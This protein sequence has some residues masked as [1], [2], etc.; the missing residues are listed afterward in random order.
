M[1]RITK[2]LAGTGDDDMA[3]DHADPADA[4]TT[5]RPT[6]E[7]SSFSRNDGRRGAP[8]SFA[9]RSGGGRVPPHDIDAERSVLSALLLDN[10]Y[11]HDVTLEVSGEDFYHPSNMALFKA[12][13]SIHEAGKPVDLITLSEHLSTKGILD[14]IGGPVFLAEIADFEATA[15]NVVHHAQ[16]VRDK[17]VKRRLISVATEIV[18]E[19][20]V[21][22]G[23]SQELLDSAEG[24]ILDLSQGQ[25]RT[26]FIRLRDEMDDT[27][28]YV[29]AI[30]NRGGGLTGV[31]TGYEDLDK[32][33]GG[34]QAG[35]LVVIAARPSMGKTAL[36]LNVARNASIED[37]R[38]VAVFSLEM[39]TRSLILR[40]L[41][42]EARVDFSAFRSSYLPTRDFTKLT[43]AGDNLSRADLWIDDS[44]D[45]SLQEI[46]SK[47]RRL[48]AESGLDLVIV[49][50]LQLARGDE[51][52]R[53]RKDLE[54]AEISKGLKALAKELEIPV[55]ALSQ[56]NRGP[57]QRDPDKRRPRL[58]DL[59][60]SGAIEQDADLIAFI[61]RDHVYNKEADAA[62]AELIVEKQRNGPTGTVKLHFE[63]R[64][65]RFDNWTGREDDPSNVGQTFVGP[66]DSPVFSKGVSTEPFDE[67]P[68]F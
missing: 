28:D 67:D 22:E 11:L 38:K 5:R 34:L 30:M 27:F 13:L 68:P 24:K 32:M 44:G 25:S 23:A 36:A 54:I 47:C 14:S 49:D 17:S 20:F 6:R 4:G 62:L 61:Y 18:E 3:K 41:S 40:L 63:G 9:E 31:P 45:I 57:E 21:E 39:T 50:Y 12:I 19:G 7:S 59:R 53:D 35:E 48:N 64:Y 51:N 2:G 46:K 1:E 15:A 29:E 56:L 55:V 33:T 37:G 26:S 42:S 10:R 60:E 66:D 16:I 43:R 58:G 8:T 65:A 52:R